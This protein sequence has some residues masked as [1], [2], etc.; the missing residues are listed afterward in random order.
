VPI[1]KEK[2]CLN[3]IIFRNKRVAQNSWSLL[4][5]ITK[6][7]A[8]ASNAVVGKYVGEKRVNFSGVCFN[9]NRGFYHKELQ[10]KILRNG[11]GK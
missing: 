10:D 1:L 11:A 2:N 3:K 6:N 8:E 4:H 5:N 9:S 7:L